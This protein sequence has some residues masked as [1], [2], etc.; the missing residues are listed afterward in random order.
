MKNVRETYQGLGKVRDGQA[1]GGEPGRD[2]HSKALH[3]SRRNPQQRTRE[4]GKKGN[5]GAS[6]LLKVVRKKNTT[7]GMRDCFF[8]GTDVA[9]SLVSDWEVSASQQPL[10][11][12]GG[13]GQVHGSS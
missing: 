6:L 7:S 13:E 2:E 1:A 5:Q 11:G 12:T 8:S 10:T 3:F 4:K 9:I